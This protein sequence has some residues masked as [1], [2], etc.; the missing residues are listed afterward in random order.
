[1]SKCQRPSQAERHGIGNW[2]NCVLRNGTRGL[3]CHTCGHTGANYTTGILVTNTWLVTNTV[4]VQLEMYRAVARETLLSYL[5]LSRTKAHHRSAKLK[6]HVKAAAHSCSGCE[7]TVTFV[8]LL[9]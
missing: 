2:V 7:A 5:Y 6:R 1:M 8:M 4:C 9:R 3:A